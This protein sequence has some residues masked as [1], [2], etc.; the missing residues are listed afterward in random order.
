MTKQMR[1]LDLFYRLLR[2]EAL[3]VQALAQE[4]HVS[5]K[6]ISRDLFECK[7][8]F[9]EFRDHAG[10]TELQY[11]QSTKRYRLRPDG[12]L[13][14][15]EMYLL[16]KILLGCRA[17]S[18]K[19]LLELTDKLKQFTTLAD[20]SRLTQLLQAEQS[21]Y[22]AVHHDCESL[23]ETLWQVMEC[24]D[25]RCEITITYFKMD[26]SCV[27]RRICPLSI[28]FS[29]YY[30]YLIAVRTDDV[31]QKPVYFRIDRIK[32]IVEHREHFDRTP[33]LHFHEGK[34]RQ[35]NQY[36]FPGKERRIRFEF[37][38]PSV[39]AVLDRLPTA[40]ILRQDENGCL[41]EAE[42]HGEG[43]KM[44]LLSQ[45]KWVKVLAPA[46]LVEELQAEISTMQSYYTK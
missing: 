18:R 43:I 23:K 38:G 2:G 11:D 41:I 26:R 5:T 25:R 42:V 21:H 27:K 1:M 28:L 22:E 24:L 3:S 33:A 34:F 15:Q 10:N 40:H 39:Q 30:F 36:M 8:F 20:R 19:E 4:F 7:A 35:K 45:G 46:E 31:A 9:S 29:E 44:F 32:H 12:F 16:L 6:T 13:S 37:T 14:N 17:L